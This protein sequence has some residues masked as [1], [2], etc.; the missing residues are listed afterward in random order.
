ME[1]QKYLVAEVSSLMRG[2]DFA[3]F[4]LNTVT[5]CHARTCTCKPIPNAQMS[6]T[7]IEVRE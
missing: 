7:H 1:I 6:A 3:R 2:P 5:I 4:M